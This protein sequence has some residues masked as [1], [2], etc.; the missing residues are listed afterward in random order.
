MLIIRNFFSQV[1]QKKTDA[2]GYVQ[3]KR[4][5]FLKALAF[6]IIMTEKSCDKVI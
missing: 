2:I 4:K 3:K 6:L 1:S 5:G